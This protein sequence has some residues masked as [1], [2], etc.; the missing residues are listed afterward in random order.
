MNVGSTPRP[1]RDL[2]LVLLVTTTSGLVLALSARW[3]IPLRDL[4]NYAGLALLVTAFAAWAI[5]YLTR[6]PR[7]PEAVFWPSVFIILFFAWYLA[8]AFGHGIDGPGLMRLGQIAA[9]LSL[10]V[11]A[12]LLGRTYNGLKIRNR[13]LI[14]IASLFCLFVMLSAFGPLRGHINPNSVGIIALLAIMVVLLCNK[15]RPKTFSLIGLTLSMASAAVAV[16]ARGSLLAMSALILTYA[17][18]PWLSSG[19]FRAWLPFIVVTSFSPLIIIAL[20]NTEWWLWQPIDAWSRDF[21]GARI[22]SGRQ[23][24]W[25][26]ILNATT[27]SP[28]TGYGP[29][30]SMEDL[31]G[32]TLS[33][34]N[35]YLQVLLQAGIVGLALFFLIILAIWAGVIR[36]ACHPSNRACASIIV[37][38]LV[39]Q[40]FE[41]TL[42]QNLFVYGAI[43]WIIAGFVLGAHK[44]DRLTFDK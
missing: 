5:L 14:L 39:L 36:H 19:K 23:D 21:F 3:S 24:Y 28:L 31:T 11:G 40:S 25:I 6:S 18:W 41:I 10:F 32:Q 22:M 17:L 2:N 34:H 37:S 8:L 33:A 13:S 42:T 9:L 29:S 44:Q 1:T 12:A 27:S 7:L 38:F 4:L 43:F 16:S 15:S 20:T 26:A 30:F 35:L